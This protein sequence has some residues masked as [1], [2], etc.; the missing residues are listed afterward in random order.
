MMD[1][2]LVDEVKVFGKGC[3]RKWCQ[4]RAGHKEVWVLE[5]LLSSGRAFEEEHRRFRRR[6]MV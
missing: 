2:G 4:C 3:T 5:E 1:E 6:C